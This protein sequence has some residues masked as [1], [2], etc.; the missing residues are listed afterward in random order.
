MAAPM[1][2][3]SGCD[4]CLYAFA[5]FVPTIINEMGYSSAQAQ[6]L[7]A[8]PYAVAAIFTVF[9]SYV[10]DRTRQRGLCNIFVS[11]FGIVGFVMLISV[12][13]PGVRYAGTFL[14]AMGIYPAISN[15]ITWASN[16]TEG[17]NARSCAPF[18]DIFALLKAALTNLHIRTGVYKRGFTLGLVIGY[19]NIQ[20]VVSSNIYRGSDA[21]NFYPGHGTV[22]AYLVLFQ[23]CGSIVQYLLLRRENSKR[24]RGERDAWLEFSPEKIEIRGDRRPDFLYTL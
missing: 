9:I 13:S 22:I 21:P 12:K 18:S 4:G 11:A 15:T 1:I 23:L 8:A 20:G 16:N 19:G 2:I 3:Y 6:L 24:L 7:S 5:L 17:M 14:G 10:A